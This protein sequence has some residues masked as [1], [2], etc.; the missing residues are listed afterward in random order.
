MAGQDSKR[1]KEKEAEKAA[2]RRRRFWDASQ[3][4]LTGWL[5]NKF[6]YSFDRSFEPADI[7]GP[8]LV[9]I[10][11]ASAYDPLFVSAAFKNKPLTFIASEHIIR[12]KFG[13]FLD[14]HISIIPHQKGARGSRTALVA[15]K[16]MKKGESIFLAVEGEQTWNGRPLPVMP[17]TGKLV[18][19]S[20]ATLVTYLIEGAYL[21]APRWALSTRKG[22]VYGRP[23]GVYG[24]EVLKEMSDREVEELIARDLG[25]D[26]WEWQKSRAD[27]PVRYKCAKG[28]NAEGIERSVFTCPACGAMGTLKSKGDSTGCS[29]GFRVRMDDTGFFDP[30]EPFETIAD[31]E[32]ADRKM[33]A[34]RM[35]EM[36]RAA[37]E[38]TVFT[39]DEVV[40][41]RIAEDH[42]DEEA[43]RG[44]L[45]LVCK[46]GEFLLK[47]GDFSFEMK[48]ISNM[49]MVLANRI[50]FSDESGYYELIAKKGSRTNLRKYIIARELLLKE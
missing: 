7:E 4:V 43:A 24:P 23:A 46:D 50:V 34:E 36:G 28:G 26:T 21:S 48:K 11:H 10:N 33:L 29:C 38:D 1:K 5:T 2:R 39:D 49:T 6:N 15:M 20:G 30:A 35:D 37:G 12:G 27:G 44:K 16:R 3:I 47:T 13:A 32:E 18:K 9:A 40:L 8:V 17:Y 25:F 19:G 41:H 45:A 14:S 22:K 42:S 31:W